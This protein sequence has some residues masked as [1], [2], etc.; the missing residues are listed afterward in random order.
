MNLS[1]RKL[2]TKYAL[3]FAAFLVAVILLIITLSG[4]LV[5]QRTNEMRTE[6]VESFS[7]VHTSFDLIALHN[8]GNYLSNRLFNPLYNID[9]ST[10]NEELTQ[11]Q[12]WLQPDSLLILDTHRR[13][14]TDGSIEN[15]SYGQKVD[16]PDNLIPGSP[17]IVPTQDGDLLY[18]VVGYGDEIAGYARVETSDLGHK[19]L[20]NVLATEVAKA[21]QEF[22]EGFLL[23]A[24]ASLGLV[25]IIT[26]I[27]SWRLSVSLS[28]PLRKMADAAEHYA[29][30][31][32]EH[33]LIEDTSDE[34]GRL[35]GSLNKMA[36]DL[37]K[38]GRLLDR[39]QEMAAFGYWEWRPG[40]TDLVLSYGAYKTFGVDYQAFEPE[41]QNLLKYVV[42]ED[43]ERVFAIL[44]GR[45]KQPVS[46]NFNIRRADGKSRTLFIRGEPE[47]HQEDGIVGFIGTIQDIT[48]QQRSN[49]QLQKLAN[50]DALTGLPNRNLFYERLNHTIKQARRRQSEFA[51]LFLDL[52]RFKS[53]NDALGH[54]VGDE[55]LRHVGKRL[56]SI[57]RESDT[58]ARMGGDEFTLIIEDL[59]EEFSPQKVAQNIIRTLTPAFKVDHRDL[60]ITTSIGVALY[61]KDA[62][63]TD[64]L[65][66]NAD[67]AMYLAKE[68]GKAVFSFFTPELDHLAH[69]RLAL[70][71]DLR[72]AL[73]ND[74]FELH[75][76]PQVD[77]N[78]NELIAIEALL[79]WRKDGELQSAEHFVPVLEETG[80]ITRL[81]GSI[82]QKAC[83]ALRQL[84]QGGVSGLRMCINL[85][86]VQFQQPELLSLIDEAV[87]ESGVTPQQLEMEITES[88]LLERDL[89][90]LN[91]AE[92][93][94]RGIR[95][96]IDDFGTGYS[97]LTYLK[98]FHVDALKIDRS[99]IRDLTNDIE[100]AQITTALLG[101][102]RSL[103]IDSIA[104]GVENEEQLEMLR[105]WHCD[106]IQGFLISRPLPFDE[107][108]T[109]VSSAHKVKSVVDSSVSV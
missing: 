33:R 15:P 3:H 29:A 13:V 96:A 18:F 40:K 77:S 103:K 44:Q 69:E 36:N 95:L 107:L 80:L 25:V 58:L 19:Q 104:E 88:T 71:S 89:S 97:S 101:L 42:P 34:L 31:N 99:F 49:E 59:N 54:D 35:A 63:E 78:T 51:L 60:F 68:Q 12:S 94:A 41:V 98:Q 62:T 61:P 85:S 56:K 27:I 53:I 39:A 23:I 43:Q 109:W 105:S 74:E 1:L 57:V 64:A 22:Q 76:Q 32:L 87:S 37:D 73:E 67:T 9:I 28:R 70:E 5:F 47:H 7:A 4:Y 8:S 92:L 17:V 81:T 10:L 21:W 50:Y 38:A 55:L 75:Y 52:D 6:L 20:S 30:G 106:L 2:S 90:Q 48:E 79:R 65:I 72:Q 26:T 11:I 83:Y 102:A 66:K 93:A 82:L 14:V 45:F 100:D 46:A 84:E 108:A 16:I 86:A 24:V 91:A